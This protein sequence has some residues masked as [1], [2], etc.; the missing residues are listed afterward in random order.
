MENHG[1]HTGDGRKEGSRK[2]LVCSDCGHVYLIAADQ[3]SGTCRVCGN[4]EFLATSPAADAPAPSQELRTFSQGL[5][6]R[7]V[8]PRLRG[9][10]IS[11]KAEPR[12]D[13]LQTFRKAPDGSS[14]EQLR[15][16]YQV[17][18]QLWAAL[19][20]SF[21][22]SAHHMA[23]LTH[24]MASQELPRAAERY[25]EH[26]SVMALLED[27]RWQAEVADLMLA[28]IEALQLAQ[29]PSYRGDYEFDIPDFLKLLPAGSWLPKVSWFAFGLFFVAKLLRLTPI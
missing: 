27:S 16:K 29:L 4:I 1:I 23:Y 13:P 11:V 21:E 15:I 9:N 3:G 5:I 25:R 20:R 8:L 28:R 24:A 2:Q 10:S 7:R 26:R 12:P 18:W 22:D 19:V 14:V 6:A 17:E